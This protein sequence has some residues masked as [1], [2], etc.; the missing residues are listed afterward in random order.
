[1]K[2]WLIRG[3]SIGLLVLIIGLLV[4]AGGFHSARAALGNVGYPVRCY[5]T[6]G[7]SPDF[8]MTCVTPPGAPDFIDNQR[9]PDGYYYLITDVMITPYGGAAGN[10]VYLDLKDA[11]GD[12]YVQSENHFRVLDGATTGQHFNA[13]MWVLLATHRLQ[14]TEMAGNQSDYDIRVN[15]ILVT[16]ISYLPVMTG[17]Q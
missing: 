3:A 9:V 17:N 16:N 1:M 13:P 2:T 15:G 4:S 5:S 12:N 11:Y 6:G 10:T 7:G 14:V 8:F